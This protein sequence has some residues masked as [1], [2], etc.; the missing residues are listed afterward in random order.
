MYAAAPRVVPK[1]EVKSEVRKDPTTKSRNKLSVAGR[2]G[3][4]AG[5][6]RSRNP[7]PSLSEQ[8]ANIG[9]GAGAITDELRKRHGLEHAK[10]V[11]FATPS[12]M[13]VVGR[14]ESKVPSPV[15]WH[16]DHCA[17]S[18]Q[19]PFQR[20]T[21]IDMQMRYSDMAQPVLRSDK[22]GGHF[23]EFKICAPLSCYGIDYDPGKRDHKVKIRLASGTDAERVKRDILPRIHRR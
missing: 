10:S 9:A 22:I 17:Y 19:H 5:R 7:R 18:F 23:F 15:A 2:R 21:R 11:L 4:P 12:M 8:L 20:G 16:T 14:L 6:R 1:N 13:F 3:G